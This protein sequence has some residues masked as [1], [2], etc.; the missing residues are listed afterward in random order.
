LG[1]S[2]GG[3]G[4]SGTERIDTAFRFVELINRGDLAGLLELMTEDYTFIA[5]DGTVDLTSRE[6]AEDGWRGYFELCPEYMIHL[7]AVHET[8]E[9]VA[10]VGRTTGSHLKLPRLAEFD[11]TIIWTAKVLDGLVAEWRIWHDT[12]EVRSQLGIPSGA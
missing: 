7:C 1:I 8:P 10:L 3:T 9:L 11:E 4:M 6:Q 5:I 12:P 2:K